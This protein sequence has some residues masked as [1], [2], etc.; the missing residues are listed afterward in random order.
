[1]RGTVGT[2]GTTTTT[3]APGRSATSSAPTP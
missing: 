3:I 2:S 1:V